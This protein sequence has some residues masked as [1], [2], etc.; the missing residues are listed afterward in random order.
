MDRQHRRLVEILN[1][2]HEAM[3]QGAPKSMLERTISDMVAYTR[4]HFMSEEKLMRSSG[5]PALSAHLIEHQVL[6]R[7]VADFERDLLA[8]RVALSIPLLNF[9]KNW[10][11]EH[12][13]KADRGYARYALSRTA[14]SVHATT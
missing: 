1:Q 12:I 5:Y 8:G 7:K 13:L 14:E 2:L 10:L 6:S 11:S 3:H 4:L 9:L